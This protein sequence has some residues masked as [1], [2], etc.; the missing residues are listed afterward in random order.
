MANESLPNS[1]HNQQLCSVDGCANIRESRGWCP[2]HYARWRKHGDASINLNPPP[3]SPETF[4]AKVEIKDDS[5]QCWEWVAGRDDKGYGNAWFDGKCVKAHRLAW[6]YTYGKWPEPMGLHGCD[7]PPCCNPKH[8]REGTYADNSAD[9]LERDRQVRGQQVG[10]VRLTE[11]IV[12]KMREMNKGGMSCRKIGKQ[13]GVS[14]WTVRD[15][16][17]GRTWKHITEN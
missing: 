12:V 9:M 5:D 10:N 17:S 15:A 7:N 13:Y 1:N 2:K 16:V 8:L 4:W 14:C 3:V 11:A 6:F